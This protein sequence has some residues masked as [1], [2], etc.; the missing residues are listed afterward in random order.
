M[1]LASL[2][3]GILGLI[4]CWNP[5][6][7]VCG[8]LALVFGIL[9]IKKHGKAVKAGEKPPGKGMAVAGVVLSVVALATTTLVVVVVMAA[10]GVAAKAVQAVA[11]DPSG[12]T[13]KALVAIEAPTK[14][15]QEA[16]KAGDPKQYLGFRTD[17]SSLAEMPQDEAQIKFVQALGKLEKHI[18]DLY[19]V[20]TQMKYDDIKKDTGK[21]VREEFFKECKAY[22]LEGRQFSMSGV[23][24]DDI[25]ELRETWG[26]YSNKEKPLYGMKFKFQSKSP[27]NVRIIPQIVVQVGTS[28]KANVSNFKKGDFIAFK[29]TL[30]GYNEKDEADAKKRLRDY[31]TPYQFLNPCW[32]YGDKVQGARTD[33]NVAK[34][35]YLG[36]NKLEQKKWL[37][38]MKTEEAKLNDGI[39][40]FGGD[41]WAGIK[42][43]GQS[44]DDKLERLGYWGGM[45]EESVDKR[46]S[47]EIRERRPEQTTMYYTLYLKLASAEKGR[48]ETK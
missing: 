44:N 22:M 31:P 19:E 13:A 38:V 28:D 37:E 36:S 15:T 24:V 10:V 11:N 26:E 3:L 27:N 4:F 43:G 9:A 45:F 16:P 17:Y 23:L 40:A 39:K 42:M 12:L 20:D 34:Q 18:F 7:W 5:L 14:P 8:I 29:G 41:P 33:Y 47:K 25:K 21:S 32:I 6:G 30:W 2:I 1:P 35:E 48:K 46:M